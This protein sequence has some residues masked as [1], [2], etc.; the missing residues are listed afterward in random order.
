MEEITTENTDKEKELAVEQQRQVLGAMAEAYQ[1]TLNLEM[2]RLH[3][4]F[5]SF[6]SVSKIPIP[7]VLLVLEIIKRETIDIAISKYIGE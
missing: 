2:G 1:E 3:N 4:Q 6:I 7:Q 5:V